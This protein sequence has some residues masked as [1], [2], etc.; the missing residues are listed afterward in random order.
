MDITLKT[1]TLGVHIFLTIADSVK[2]LKSPRDLQEDVR[3]MLKRGH[4]DPDTGKQ[5]KPDTGAAIAGRVD[6]KPLKL[7]PCPH[8]DSSFK[9]SRGLNNHITRMHP[10]KKKDSL[11]STGDSP[12]VPASEDAEEPTSD[13][14]IA[15]FSEK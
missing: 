11:L 7:L 1:Q 6:P 14:L 13:D 15:E 10:A 2:F 8:C 12:L 5:L 9:G 4:V 3:I